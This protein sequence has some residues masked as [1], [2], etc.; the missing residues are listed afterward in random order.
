MSVVYDTAVERNQDYLYITEIDSDT[1]VL[2]TTESGTG[3]FYSMKVDKL[4]LYEQTQGQLNIPTSKP[5]PKFKVGDTVKYLL[6]PSTYTVQNVKWN[7]YFK[8]YE[9]TIVRDEDGKSTL[10]LEQKLE[11][12]LFDDDDLESA[13]EDLEI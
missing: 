10:E 9:Y 3:D 6:R 13:L 4:E 1:Y 8:D 7:D 12:A 11:P 2:D 5:Q